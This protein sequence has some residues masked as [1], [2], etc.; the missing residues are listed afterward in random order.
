[1]NTKGHGVFFIITRTIKLQQAAGSTCHVTLISLL[2][3]SDFQRLESKAA[4][5]STQIYIFS[6]NTR[7]F[8]LTVVDEDVS[9]LVLFVLEGL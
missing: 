9:S 1:M 8:E 7:V 2:S 4:S 6:Q 5:A 3:T